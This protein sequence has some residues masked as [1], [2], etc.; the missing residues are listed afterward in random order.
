[1]MK[2]HVKEVPPYKQAPADQREK[3]L[4]TIRTNAL[5]EVA[6]KEIL[7]RLTGPVKI[8]IIYH[9]GKGRADSTNIIGGIADALNKIA[10]N[11]DRQIKEV[12]YSE[13][14]KTTDEYWVS[15]TM[16]D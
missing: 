12:H 2:L 1:M 5:R 3:Q 8:D 4:Q 15:I 10:Y 14:K 6:T 7:N 9:R 11:D 16:Y 13:N